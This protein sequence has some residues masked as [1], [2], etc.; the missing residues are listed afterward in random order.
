MQFYRDW[1]ATRLLKAGEDV[2]AL[3]VAGESSLW[4][5]ARIGLH[6]T[7]S[8]RV[9]EAQ[10]R[11]DRYG[12]SLS[13]AYL[14]ERL[15]FDQLPRLSDPERVRLALS[16]AM[17]DCGSAL[18][19]L[20]PTALQARAACQIAIGALS[21]AE[22]T[23]HLSAASNSHRVEQHA[24]RSALAARQG[25]HDEARRALNVM[26]SVS[27]LSPAVEPRAAPIT[28]DALSCGGPVSDGPLV[29]VI[30]PVRNGAAT[31]RA[32]AGSVLA[33]SHRNIELVVVDD[34]SL[35]DT[36]SMLEAIG[37]RR[38]RVLR[39]PRCFGAYAARNRGLDAAQGTIIAFNDADDWSHPHRIAR[40]VDRLARGA[41]AVMS[42]LV[43]LDE[44]GALCAQR[45]FPLVRLNP[46]S[47]VL[48]NKL[49]K[50][51]GP[52]DEVRAGAD[53]EYIGRIILHCGAAAIWHDRVPL[54]IASLRS[55]SLTHDSATSINHR[56]GLVDRTRYFESWM[57]RH[58]ALVGQR[59]R[60][61]RADA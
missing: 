39:Q 42:R 19:L 50:R 37:D 7:V 18:S 26:L 45:V 17:W 9:D 15:D 23:L 36:V 31:V 16:C 53:L 2:R 11:R 29:S 48:T 41:S 22:K 58:A 40:A 30:M 51:L 43:R 27:G 54:T 5:L 6:L 3:Q 13:R 44:T 33:Q 8:G 47:L 46:A 57:R 59:S 52:Y 28:L 21:E 56:Q 4:L 20:P 34:A 49:A 25:R 60:R 24:L 61:A 10:S 55:G 38:L 1:R 14:G 35:D 12:T 32:A